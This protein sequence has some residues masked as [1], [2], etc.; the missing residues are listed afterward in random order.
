[1]LRLK[2]SALTKQDGSFFY[3]GSPFSGV[4]FAMSDGEMVNAIEILE[5]IETGKYSPPLLPAP[6]CRVVDMELLDPEDEDD[7]EPFLCLEGERF[8]G[9]A[10]EFDGDFCT[11]ELLYVRGWPQSQYTY[12]RTG[13]PESV[14]LVEDDLSQTCQWHENGQLRK[15]KVASRSSFSFNMELRE[16]G[17]LSVLG[18]DGDCFNQ[19]NQMADRL[20]V[21]APDAD[22]FMD[23]LKSAE[24]LSLSGDSITDDEFGKLALSGALDQTERISLFQTGVSI[25]GLSLLKAN[26]RL[27]KLTIESTTVSLDAARSF[28]LDMPACHVELNREEVVAAPH[29]D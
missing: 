14:E 3:N 21:P 22:S 24:F 12:Y 17:C 20:V 27:S 9:L 19:A 13:Q 4:A 25:A 1:M 6:D 23:G 29:C 5:G 7:Y 16:D 26:R 11:G 8:S 10:L 28:K 15:Y 2:R 18:M